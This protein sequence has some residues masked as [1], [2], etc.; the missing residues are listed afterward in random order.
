MNTKN[1]QAHK[2]LERLQ[3]AVPRIPCH[4]MHMCDHLDLTQV[5]E[6]TILAGM[7]GIDIA[8]DPDAYVTQWIAENIPSPEVTA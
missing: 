7:R 6:A 4:A 5:S 8:A 2:A 1:D 3:A